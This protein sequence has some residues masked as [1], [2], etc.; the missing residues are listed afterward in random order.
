MRPISKY[1][2][3]KKSLLLVIAAVF[4]LSSFAGEIQNCICEENIEVLNENESCCSNKTDCSDSEKEVN[5]SNHEN[6]K[7]DYCK[8]CSI[9][10]QNIELPYS[11]TNNKTTSKE[12]LKY[13]NE[14]T[15][16][17]SY[18]YSEHIPYTGYIPG[19]PTRIY[20]SVSNLRI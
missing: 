3:L 12:I 8:V 4:F 10:K 20:I 15:F 17:V 2:K 19:I 16:S 14:S 11:I 9:T 7:C 18:I 13:T 6:H 5:D 1:K